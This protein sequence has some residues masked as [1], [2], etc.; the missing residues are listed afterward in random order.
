MINSLKKAL[1]LSHKPQRIKAK[2]PA[3]LEHL[4]VIPAKGWWN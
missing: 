1:R 3:G 2:L 4:E